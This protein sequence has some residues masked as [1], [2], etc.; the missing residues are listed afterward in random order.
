MDCA[1][2]T[3]KV[4]QSG[5]NNDCNGDCDIPKPTNA[6]L[7]RNRFAELQESDNT[8]DEEAGIMTLDCEGMKATGKTKGDEGQWEKITIT[9][10]SG[11]AISV[12]PQ[13]IA[14]DLP[15][16]ESNAS[17]NNTTFRAAN[18]GI[19]KSMG[20]RKIKGTTS[21]GLPCSASFEVSKVTKTLGAVSEMIDKGNKVVFDEDECYILNKETNRKTR[22]RRRGGAFEF[23]IYIYIYYEK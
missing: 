2:V 4:I 11:A 6:I 20:R 18:G 19:L 14:S 10:D 21:N 7:H 12:M 17:R 9:V 15:I 8:S 23:D 1:T 22:I 5:Y 16:H 3:E 13:D